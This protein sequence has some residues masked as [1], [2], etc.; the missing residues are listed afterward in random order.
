MTVAVE[1]HHPPAPL[2]RTFNAVLRVVLTP[3]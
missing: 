1:G 2:V 3:R